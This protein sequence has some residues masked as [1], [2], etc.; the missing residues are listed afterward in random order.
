MQKYILGKVIDD[1][2]ANNVKDIEGVEKVVWGF[3]IAFYKSHWNSF[4]V[5]STNRS[6]RNNVKSKFSPQI[7]KETNTNKS[8]NSVNTLYVSPLPP[9]I[10]AKI[11]KEVNE[12]SKYF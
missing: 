5:D 7:I 1:D 12:I 3:I 8:K 6:F 10:L 2:K 9:P 11:A 4:L